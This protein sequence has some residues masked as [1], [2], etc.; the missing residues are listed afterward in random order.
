[1]TKRKPGRPRSPDSQRKEVLHLY[2]PT[3]L[4]ERLKKFIAS[5]ELKPT[6]SAIVR[7]A[8]NEYLTKKGA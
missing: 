8:V 3:K 6:I 7:A 1:M 4:N 2:L 5:D